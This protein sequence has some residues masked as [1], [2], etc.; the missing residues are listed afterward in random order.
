[1]CG[2][3]GMNGMNGMNE[4][5]LFISSRAQNP[6]PA[7]GKHVPEFDDITPDT[8]QDKHKY[9]VFGPRSVC[10]TLQGLCR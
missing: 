5:K 7:T 10:K 1:M 8:R 6:T 2:M 4:S 3:S 9:H